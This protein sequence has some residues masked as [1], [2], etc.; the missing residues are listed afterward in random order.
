M[1]GWKVLDQTFDRLQKLI[2]QLEIFGES[3][4]QED[5]NQKFLRSLSPEWNT[6]T[7]VWRNK[8]EI[9]TLSLDDLYNNLK[10][11][12]VNTAFGVTSVGTQVN[13][14]NIDNLS[15]IN[16]ENLEEV[17][18][19]WQ[20]A[21]LTMRAR[22]FLKNTGRKLNLNGNETVAFDKTEVECYNCHKRGDFARECKALR[23]QDNKKKKST[24]RNV[25][26]ETTNSTALVFCD[27][28]RETC[29]K[30][31]ET[32]KSQN[33]QMLKDL[34]TSKINA[35]TYKTELR[36]K[37]ELAQKQ[38]DE[39]ELTV[40]K[41]KN[42]SKSLSKLLDS[43]IADKCKAVKKPV[44]KTSEVKA[45]ED[46]PKVIS[47]NSGPPIIEDWIPDSEDEDV[48]KPKI[49]KKTIKPSFAK[50]ENIVP[51]AVLM[52]SGI[53]SVN[54]A[55]QKISKATVTVN[56]ARPVN[57]AHPKTTMNAAKPRPK[58]VVNTSRPKAVLNAV[59]GNEVYAVKALACWVWKPKIKILDH[60]SKHNNA[61]IT[62][63]KF[64]YVDSQ[65]RFK[66]TPLFPT[67]TVQAQEDMGEGSAHPTDPHHTPTITQPSTSKPQKKQKPRKP[68]RHDT[69][70]TQPSGPTTNVED[71]AFNEENVS[72][73]SNDTLHS[74]I[75]SLKR[76]VKK[77]ERSQK[78]KTHGMKIL[79]KVGLSTRVESSDEESLGEEDTSKHRRNIADIDA[80]KEITLVDETAEDQRGFDDQEMFD[81]WVLDNEEVV[82]K[83]AVADKEVSAV[84]EVNAASITTPISVAATTTTAAT[85]PTIFMDEITL[86][87]ALIEIKT[88]RPKAK[89]MV[90]QEP[91]E[92][93]TPTPI[94]YSQ[95][96]LKVH[97][98]GKG[99]MVEEPLK[100][101]KKDQISIDKQEAQRLQA[102]C[103]ED[104]RLARE[105]NEANNA[106]IEQWNDVQ[107][108]IEANYE[109]AQ[110][111]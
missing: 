7:I 14:T 109:L 59:K 111:L 6:H 105:K 56:T 84:E 49:E 93:P 75:D 67:M 66:E 81:T 97:D 23:L 110:K 68:R 11:E 70:K 69:E 94:V 16:P 4:S 2:S 71:K 62:L 21:T 91:S 37:L 28:L 106:V 55:R 58:A 25:P 64:D 88:S 85:T 9:D 108:K 87:K 52:K 46:K 43:Q 100:M 79:Y 36:R 48:S 63:K 76:R 60:V 80:D 39:I 40:E 61:S 29:L 96:S 8:P 5:V 42:S 107:A 19:K 26:V 99:I 44:I 98:K 22:R 95:Q 104:E 38:K 74:E 20:M 86:A 54:A 57:N 83:K 15:D 103:N 72:K 51:R 47:N 92:T 73:H 77:L 13:A 78:S 24:R 34:R 45:S 33:E 18:L 41:F 82:V 1:K 10:N 101:K 53:K 3:I 32:L 27:G 17:D 31:V 35:I 12:A 30:T 65:G 102:K 90:M 89:G 50:I